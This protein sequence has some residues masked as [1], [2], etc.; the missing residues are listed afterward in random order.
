[1]SKLY[2]ADRD[3]RRR[4]CRGRDRRARARPPHAHLRL[5]HDRRRQVD[6]RPP[7]RLRD[8]D[9]GA[10][11]LERHDGRGG[12][13]ARRRGRRTATTSCSA[14]TRSRRACSV[15]TGSRSTTAWRRSATI[16]R[17]SAWDE[18]TRARHRRVRRLL[19]RRPATSSSAS[20]G[21]SWI[22]AP[23]RDG[24]RPG[25]FCAT[26]VP[27]VHPYVFMNYTGD[28]RSVLTLAHELGHGLHGYLAA[29][30]RAL[31]RARRR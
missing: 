27:G 22:D 8:V 26:N 7:A 17:R 13:G 20:S 9:L 4:A 15:S 14:T 3:L 19:A 16:R 1:M 2:S 10:Q 18:A 12:A 11:P 23:P 28:R 5:Q 24:K 6:R 30:A 25:A 21:T 31:Q 29:A